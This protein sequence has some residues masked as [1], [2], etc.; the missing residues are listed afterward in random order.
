MTMKMKKLA[1]EE[2][3]RAF[4]EMQEGDELDCDDLILK[5]PPLENVAHWVFEGY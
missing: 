3:S 1:L 4:Q 2:L 5:Y